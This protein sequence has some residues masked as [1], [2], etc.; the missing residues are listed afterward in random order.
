MTNTTVLPAAASP[1]AGAHPA[2]QPTVWG[3]PPAQIHDRYWAARGVQVVRQ[4]E[5]SHIV[6]G[7]EIFLLIA[8]RSLVIFRLTLPVENLTWIKPKLLYLRLHDQRHQ[9]YRELVITD[10]HDRFVGFDRI[11]GGSRQQLTRVGLTTDRRIAEQWQ[12]AASPSAGWRALRASIGTNDRAAMSL[13]GRVFDAARDEE[14]M[15]CLTEIVQRWTRPDMTIPRVRRHSSDTWIDPDGQVEAGATV[16]GSVWVGAGRHLHKTDSVVGPAILWDDP[17]HR[18]EIDLLQWGDIEPIP[19]LDRPVQPRQLTSFARA[20]KRLFD[21]MFALIG[22]A[23]SLPLY[24]LIM[25]AIVLEDGLPVFFVHRRETIGEA[26]FPCLKFRSMRRDADQIKA[27]LEAENQADGPQFYIE[28]DPR[29]TRVGKFLR[30]Y[31]LDELPQLWNILLGQMSVVGPRP[32]PY[33]ENQFC[34]PW[35]EARLSVR[36]GLTGLWQVCRTRQPGLDF[37]EWIKF[38]IEY[39]ETISWTLDMWI[40]WRTIMI[41]LQGPTR[42]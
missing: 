9:G 30:D 5:R 32:S 10:H 6:S 23:L 38:D 35:R 27:Q 14:V 28:N 40:I 39:V 26:E 21:I 20:C 42:P 7:A 2:A 37:Q 24:P 1:R 17:H 8:P 19:N 18:P 16:I 29:L 22:I 34:P 11:Y 25:L 15:A 3:L 33:A 12:K 41:V 36:P 31:Q 4:G 13:S